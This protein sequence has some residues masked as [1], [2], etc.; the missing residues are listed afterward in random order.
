MSDNDACKGCKHS[1]LDHGGG[2]GGGNWLSYRPE[3]GYRPAPTPCRVCMCTH[4]RT[5]P[6]KKVH[7]LR[8][9]R[10][11][12]KKRYSS[13]MDQLSIVEG[14]LKMAKVLDLGAGKA[15]KVRGVLALLDAAPQAEYQFAPDCTFEVYNPI[16]VS[17][18]EEGEDVIG[19]ANVHTDGKRLLADMFITRE[20]PQRLDIENKKNLFPVTSF[21][22]LETEGDVFRRLLVRHVYLSSVSPDER[23]PAIGTV[24]L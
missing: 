5:W 12:R 9:I 13:S 10:E 1:R 2:N 22:L 14:E 4:F 7:D 20:C 8:L 19:H 15:L 17:S 23:L 3:I 18:D 11:E 24:V 21:E 16:K 6:G